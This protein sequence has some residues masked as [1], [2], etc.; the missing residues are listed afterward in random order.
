M[1]YI[2]FDKKNDK[3]ILLKNIDFIDSNDSVYYLRNG[4]GKKEFFNYNLTNINTLSK[5][6]LE[7]YKDSDENI[8]FILEK[9][10][11]N[12]LLFQG[13]SFELR[14]YVLIVQIDKKIYTF[15]YP[16]LIAHFGVENINMAE[17]LDFLE[18]QISK[19]IEVT[20]MINNLIVFTPKHQK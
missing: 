6:I 19:G 10:K 15:L 8:Q 5:I 7:K 17:F 4:E 20:D 2:I 3:D 12:H 11:K 1:P 14:T 16:L 9:L 18:L 13:N